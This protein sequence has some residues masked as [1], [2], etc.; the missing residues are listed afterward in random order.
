MTEQAPTTTTDSQ[1][2]DQ[3]HVVGEQDDS[4]E[5]DAAQEIRDHAKELGLSESEAQ[6]AVDE[7]YDLAPDTDP[8]NA[9]AD[10]DDKEAAPKGSFESISEQ[11]ATVEQLLEK[12]D[13]RL[14]GIQES[15]AKIGEMIGDLG[16]I[17]KVLILLLTI[18]AMYQEKIEE[19]TDEAEKTT[20]EH[21]LRDFLARVP[22]IS[23]DD[24]PDWA[25]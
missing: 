7:F 16:E 15:L 24:I 13:E 4:D 14:D 19:T 12:V 25:K 2:E 10:G 21:D 9:P 22:D 1:H 5:R 18:T 8:D 11:L 17:L 23:E 20:L 6:Q 3:P